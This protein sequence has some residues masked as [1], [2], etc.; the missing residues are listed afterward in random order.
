MDYKNRKEKKVCQGND[1]PVKI[2]IESIIIFTDFIHS[3]VNHSLFSSYFVSNLKSALI[4]F[5]F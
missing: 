5:T 3:N 4:T 1:V 2:I